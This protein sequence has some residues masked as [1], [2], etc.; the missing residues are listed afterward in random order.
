VRL[1][2]EVP[3]AVS[4]DQK[5]SS[6]IQAAQN[7]F[8]RP[9]RVYPEY[10]L[11]NEG[12][13]DAAY[14]YND[15]LAFAGPH[16]IEEWL[17]GLSPVRTHIRA[18]H[19]AGLLSQALKGT[20]SHLSLSLAQLPMEPL[21]SNGDVVMRWLGMKFP[22]DYDI[23]DDNISFV[24]QTPAGYSPTGLQ[25]GIMVDNWVE[26]IPEKTAHTGVAVHYNNPNSEPPQ[27]CLLAVS[28][29]L[30]GSWSWDDLMDTLSET[31]EWAKK[32]AV[33]PDLLNKTFYAQVLPA[34]YAPVSGS[35]DTP[36]L[37]FGRNIIEKPKP[38]IFDLIKINDFKKFNIE[39]QNPE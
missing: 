38:G 14:G 24:F 27:T 1:L 39:F 21:D 16:A 31:L 8:G 29:D 32:R 15:Y 13:L 2:G 11:Y 6:L 35:E 30:N 19:Q 23:P 34:I 37:D 20:D 25:A 10:R 9:F 3:V 18:F 22:A 4:E 7:L 33:D 36:N 28:P 12:S 17:Q 26:E 5:V